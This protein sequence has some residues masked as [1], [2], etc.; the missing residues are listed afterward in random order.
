M[1]TPNDI[2][3]VNAYV[4][5]FVYAYVYMSV[6]VCVINSNVH[7]IMEIHTGCIHQAI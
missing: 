1:H 4:Y 3:Y 7:D 6:C 5:D 2:I